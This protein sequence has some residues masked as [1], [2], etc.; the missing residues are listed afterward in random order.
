MPLQAQA[1]FMAAAERYGQEDAEM[2]ALLDERNAAY[3]QLLAVPS[4]AGAAQMLPRVF[5]YV[6]N[7]DELIMCC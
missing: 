2:E 5:C 4:A 6:R 7:N 1:A 3:L